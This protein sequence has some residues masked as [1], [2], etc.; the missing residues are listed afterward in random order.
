MNIY[1]KAFSRSNSFH[2]IYNLKMGTR[3]EGKALDDILWDF[4]IDYKSHI[5]KP[6]YLNY[7]LD[8]AVYHI[9]FSEWFMLRRIIELYAPYNNVLVQLPIFRSFFSEDSI[10]IPRT[11][12]GIVLGNT[13]F[14]ETEKGYRGQATHLFFIEE[15]KVYVSIHL[16]FKF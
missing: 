13:V 14:S 1:K 7:E 3:W 11:L 4:G 10:E 12:E 6:K 9:S 5:I 2:L 15:T 8:V 16:T